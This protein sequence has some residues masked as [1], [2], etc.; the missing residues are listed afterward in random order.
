MCDIWVCKVCIFGWRGCCKNCFYNMFYKWCLKSK[1][2]LKLV[3]ENND[4]IFFIYSYIYERDF[5]VV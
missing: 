5:F 4:D 2:I 1:I 3:K